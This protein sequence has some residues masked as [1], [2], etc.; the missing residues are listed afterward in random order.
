MTR[1]SASDPRKLGSSD[2]E[3]PMRWDDAIEVLEGWAGRDVVVVPFLAPGISL[4]PTAA[5]LVLEREG[6]G[7]ARLAMPGM[8]IALRRST[9]IEAGWVPGQEDRGL[10]VVQGG[11]RVDVF[12]DV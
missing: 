4:E 8:P 6:G 10:S 7:T 5:A 2:D 11:V 12:L 1:F 3:I 9:F